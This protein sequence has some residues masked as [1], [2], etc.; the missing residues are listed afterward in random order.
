MIIWAAVS[1]SCPFVSAEES[2]SGI[3]FCGWL[4]T[5]ISWG[6]VV[7]T[8]PFS[9]CVCFKVRLSSSPFLSHYVPVSR[10]KKT[11]A[12]FL[13]RF[14]SASWSEK[15]HFHLSFLTLR[16]IQ[17]RRVQCILSFPSHSA[18]ASL[19][20]ELYPSH[21]A[22]ASRSKRTKQKISWHCPF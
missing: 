18:S 4:L 6:L 10:S 12:P 9:L 17:G 13:S 3:G 2:H 8:L 15:K 11:F 7:V 22:C 19:T 16:M 14:A 1:N 21:S 20:F 5:A